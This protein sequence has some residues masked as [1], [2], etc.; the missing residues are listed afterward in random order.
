MVGEVHRGLDRFKEQLSD[1]SRANYSQNRRNRILGISAFGFSGTGFFAGAVLVLARI[2]PTTEPLRAFLLVVAFSSF[3]I[4][5]CVVVLLA[6]G[7]RMGADEIT[8]DSD[9]IGLL[10]PSGKRFQLI[11]HSLPAGTSIIDRSLAPGVSPIQH[12][13]LW[14][15]PSN[16]L[17]L[18]LLQGIWRPRTYL[19]RRA[20]QRLISEA[21]AA[22][23]KVLPEGSTL[24]AGSPVAKYLLK[25]GG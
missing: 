23:V 21:A 5:A 24:R 7:Y 14:P 9:G 11:W 25:S 1:L 4:S 15:G 20:Y 6:L 10:M 2:I 8:I 13:E 19:S 3:W 22:G 16:L 18:L 17:G 12:F